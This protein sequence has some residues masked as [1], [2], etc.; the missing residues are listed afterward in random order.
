VEFLG[1]I[2]ITLP[3]ST[4]LMGQPDRLIQNLPT[5]IFLNGSGA[6]AMLFAQGLMIG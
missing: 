6:L 3:V 5:C 4:E 1:M 2:Y